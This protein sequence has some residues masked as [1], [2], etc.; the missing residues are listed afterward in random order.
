M[1]EEFPGVVYAVN[2]FCSNNNLTIEYL[3]QDGCPSYLIKKL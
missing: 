3:T 2:E 1:A